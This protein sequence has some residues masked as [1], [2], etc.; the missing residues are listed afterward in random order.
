MSLEQQQ[1][2]K[3]LFMILWITNDPDYLQVDFHKTSKF[4]KREYCVVVGNDIVYI[5]DQAT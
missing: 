2:D 4:G 3:P 1:C 5:K